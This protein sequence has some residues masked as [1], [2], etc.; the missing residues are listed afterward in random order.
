MSVEHEEL[1]RKL[2]NENNPLAAAVGFLL[3]DVEEAET[4]RTEELSSELREATAHADS[5][6]SDLV[7]AESVIEDKLVEIDA[8]EASLALS[9]RIGQ[10]L[11]RS[12]RNSK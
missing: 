11:L 8:L 12:K 9:N 5:L 3:D 2:R 6:S 1:W 7:V 10:A 4:C